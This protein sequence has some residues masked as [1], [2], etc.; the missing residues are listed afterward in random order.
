MKTL[1]TVSAAIELG[2]GMALM[3]FPSAVVKLLLGVPLDSAPAVLLG[4]LAGTALFAL[5]VA[6]WLARGNTSSR[7]V[8]SAMLFYNLAAVAVFLL[9][10]LGEKL[11]GIAL[12]P[13]VI[14]H[15]AM[16]VWCAR[17]LMTSNT[18]SSQ[19]TG[20]STQK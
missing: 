5:G 4:R 13:A 1:N 18:G 16:G 11:A 20:G 9:A 10:A 19:S 17:C 14:L 6:C 7:A 3:G 15:T 2:A 12:W 8:V